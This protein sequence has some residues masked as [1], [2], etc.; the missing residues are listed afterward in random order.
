M[1]KLPKG[2][3]LTAGNSVAQMFIIV[4]NVPS[5]LLVKIWNVS[6][7][8]SKGGL[9][10]IHLLSLK[11]GF[12]AFN[13]HCLQSATIFS[14]REFD[15]SG[16]GVMFSFSFILAIILYFSISLYHNFLISPFFSFPPFLIY[17]KKG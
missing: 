5:W 11:Q 3:V 13:V 8:L 12:I 16:P 2:D 14:H 9:G 15:A 1:D 17:P 4:S 7:F 6:V 10:E